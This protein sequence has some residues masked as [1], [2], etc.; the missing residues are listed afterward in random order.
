MF[1]DA[2]P[3]KMKGLSGVK[4][5]V[6]QPLKFVNQARRAAFAKFF[7]RKSFSPLIGFGFATG[8]ASRKC[9]TTAR[10]QKRFWNVTLKMTVL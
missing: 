8:D 3:L 10:E 2:S 6:W 1:V 5:W 9:Y 7:K 4:T